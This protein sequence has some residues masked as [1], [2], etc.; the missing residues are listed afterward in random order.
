MTPA[1][2]AAPS[3][4]PMLDLTDP[5]KNVLVSFKVI[6]RVAGDLHIEGIGR[7]SVLS[8]RLANR[9]SLDRVSNRGS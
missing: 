3:R 4:C 7:G 5:L 6:Q 8:E 1:T 9:P 2:P